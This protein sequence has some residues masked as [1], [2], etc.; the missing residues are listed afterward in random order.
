MVHSLAVHS[1]CT[2]DGNSFF[3][4]VN[5]FALIRCEIG[6][7]ILGE[8]IHFVEIFENFGKYKKLNRLFFKVGTNSRFQ[9]SKLSINISWIKLERLSSIRLK[10]RCIDPNLYCIHVEFSWSEIEY[11]IHIKISYVEKSRI[12]ST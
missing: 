3:E 7:S 6:S 12:V 11:C 10:D 4:K 8:R 2:T 5:L 9:F 1:P